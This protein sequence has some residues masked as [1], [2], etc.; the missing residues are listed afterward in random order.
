[1]HGKMV[2]TGVMD[3]EIVNG[4]GRIHGALVRSNVFN[5]EILY[6]SR[7]QRR[8]RPSVVRCNSGAGTLSGPRPAEPSLA[9]SSGPLPEWMTSR[10]PLLLLA[11]RLSTFYSS[12]IAVFPFPS[13]APSFATNPQLLLISSP[14]RSLLA[15]KIFRGASTED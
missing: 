11:S 8:C 6:V 7:M 9:H 4:R 13:W 1:M 10:V 2:K 15:S 14:R 5:Y 3:E 12:S